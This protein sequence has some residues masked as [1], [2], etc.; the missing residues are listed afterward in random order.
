MKEYAIIELNKKLCSHFSIG[1]T[2]N[3]NK[4]LVKKFGWVNAG[5][6]SFYAEKYRAFSNSPN[7]DGWFYL[8]HD[9]IID[10]LGLPENTVIKA[11][12][13][14]ISNGFLSTRNKGIPA[15][16][17]LFLNGNII[18][19]ALYENKDTEIAE[20]YPP[21]KSDD[22]PRK[23]RGL[24]NKTIYNKEECS[25]EHFVDFGKIDQQPQQRKRTVLPIKMVHDLDIPIERVMFDAFYERYPRK[26]QPFK[27]Q[28]SWNTLCRTSKRERPTLRELYKS[29]RE[30][31]NTEQWQSSKKNIP[32]PATWINQRRWT[33]DA[34]SMSDNWKAANNQM[35]NK[36]GVRNVYK[37]A[38]YADIVLKN[39]KNE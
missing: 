25:I 21:K 35:S 13:L 27:A 23:S 5:I 38:T 37:G 24:N 26:E 16:Q 28:K 30:Y 32:L 9:K 36:Q 10:A 11:K 15:K 2:Y 20:Q 8:T 34:Q 12:Q 6:L 19:D 31:S 33:T 7:F 4:D 18:Y 14:F 17:W 1:Y 3:I 39:S 29:I 22:R